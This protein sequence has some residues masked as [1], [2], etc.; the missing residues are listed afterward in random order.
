MQ[1][2]ALADRGREDGRLRPAALAQFP[3]DLLGA[4][5]AFSAAD[6][7]DAR[8]GF[9]VVGATA[10]LTQRLSCASWCVWVRG[11]DDGRRIVASVPPRRGRGPACRH[12]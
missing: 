6:F 1:G 11:L 9:A 4:R 12:D 7:E 3:V 8:Q 2:S 10:R 5:P